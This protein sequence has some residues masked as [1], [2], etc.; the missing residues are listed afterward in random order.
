MPDFSRSVVN[1]GLAPQPI[2]AYTQAIR[3]RG[4]GLMFI[5]GQVA[6]DAGGN[7]VG[8]GDAAGQTRQVFENI[9]QILASQ[10]ATMSNIV[11]FTTYVVRRSSVEGFLQGRSAAF[12]DLYPQGD[13]PPNTL[14]VIDGL[15]RDDF[16]VEISAIAALP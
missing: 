8:E 2:G 5:A 12:P 11:E 3:T 6:L 15:V 1:T 4:A 13:Y 7:L 16:L 10:D 9:R 14:L